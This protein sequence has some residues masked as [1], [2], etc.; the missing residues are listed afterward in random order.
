[1]DF[2]TT[3]TDGLNL[4][5]HYLAPG[6]SVFSST[7]FANKIFGVGVVLEGYVGINDPLANSQVIVGSGAQSPW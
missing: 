4:F 1:M 5:G 3:I 7:S 2:S 6:D